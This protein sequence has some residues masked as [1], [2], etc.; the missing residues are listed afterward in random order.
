MAGKE[1]PLPEAYGTQQLKLTPRD[2]H[3]IHARWDFTREQLLE[4]NAQAAEGHLVL[5]LFNKSTS[6]PIVSETHVHPESVRWLVHAPQPGAPYAAEIGFYEKQGR[7]TG[8]AAAEPVCTPPAG[9]STDQRF[10]IATL[11]PEGTL[12]M[13][14]PLQMLKPP[15]PVLGASEA[16]AGD[17]LTSAGLNLPSSARAGGGLPG[18]S[19]APFPLGVS[20]WSSAEGVSSPS[21]PSGAPT[22]P[23]FRLEVN[24]D[25]IVYGATEA[26]AVLQVGDRMVPLSADGTFRLRFTLPDGAY[27]LP[28]KA[29]AAGTGEQRMA[30]LHIARRTEASGPVGAAPPDPG[31]KPPAAENL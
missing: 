27:Q 20:S 16:M 30:T 5:R 3:W 13:G 19:G 2:P 25:L 11:S 6:G 31:S 14:G 21:S 17:L 24:A 29:T 1:Q 10:D 15:A 12:Q 8:L 28:L 7:W 18:V 22:Q 23:A 26:N 4:V 9:P